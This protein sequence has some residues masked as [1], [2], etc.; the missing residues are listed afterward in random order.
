M[1][2]VMKSNW[3]AEPSLQICNS[4]RFPEEDV[5][6]VCYSEESE[7]S[8]LNGDFRTGREVVRFLYKSS[9][10]FSKAVQD[11][12]V[13]KDNHP[14]SLKSGNG[15]DVELPV[16]KEPKKFRSKRVIMRYLYGVYTSGKF[17]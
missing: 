2:E 17:L 6:P 3:H 5:C 13:V 12:V 10:R 8:D 15:N 16:E 11:F 9:D 7:E 14:E 4:K 1:T